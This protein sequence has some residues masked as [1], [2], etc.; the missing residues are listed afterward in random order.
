[1]TCDPSVTRHRYSLM[2]VTECDKKTLCSDNWEGAQRKC[3]CRRCL[4]SL[5]QTIMKKATSTRRGVSVTLMLSHFMTSICSVYIG[6]F[7]GMTKECQ[8]CQSLPSETSPLQN[9][10][11]ELQRQHRQRIDASNSYS[12][13]P[14]GMRQLFVGMGRLKRD[15]F[16]RVYD[17][18]VPMN[19][20]VRG[21]EEVLILYGG[22]SL[23]PSDAVSSSDVIPLFESP[24]DATRNC[25]S[26][27]M[28]LMRA[29]ENGQCLAVVG[30][31][32]SPNVHKWMRFSEVPGEG[33]SL[34][35]PMK[36]VSR[37][38]SAITGSFIDVPKR[39]YVQHAFKKLTEYLN[40]FDETVRK[41]RPVARAVVKG[42]KDN[43]IIIMIC[44]HG[45]SELFINFVCSARSRN[46]DTSRILL[47]ATDI[48]TKELAEALGIATFYDEKVCASV[49]C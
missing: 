5:A 33:V 12:L 19:P 24:E 49:S 23:P 26:L 25:I 4:V 16:A 45:Q 37:S 15:D 27:N 29:N 44:N 30:Q 14:P 6:Y 17:S 7:L 48:E 9:R 38:H 18:G 46:L 42:H 22:T 11:Q 40:G 31:W 43:T 21:N 36:L 13:L 47:F 8:P 39:H 20:S 41:L 3:R 1:M 2:P 35:Q 28:V 34:Q 10:R 32:P